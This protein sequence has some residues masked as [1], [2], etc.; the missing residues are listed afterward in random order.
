MNRSLFT[1]GQD[2]GERVP[3]SR[4][5]LK[6]CPEKIAEL[7]RYWDEARGEAPMP[8]RAAIR[9]EDIIAHLPGVLLVDVEGQD[10]HGVGIFRYRVVGTA[11]VT[12]RDHDPTG[13]LVQEGFFGPSKEDVLAC[14]ESVRRQRSFLHDPLE[15]TTPE[16]RWRDEHTLFLPLSE[17]G[18]T[19][20]QILVYSERRR[21]D[22]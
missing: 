15:Y 19:V 22:R 10:E 7:F 2:T 20:S 8:T 12:L 9:P 18:Q 11:E 21:G 5:F 14:Y 16:G 17:D 1:D 6:K 13:K 3:S 4:S